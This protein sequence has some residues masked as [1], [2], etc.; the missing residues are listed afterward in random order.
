MRNRNVTSNEVSVDEQAFKNT[1]EVTVDEEGFEVVDETVEFRPSVEMEIQAKVDS[2]HPNGRQ[3][4]R[5][6]NRS[7]SR[8]R[9]F[10]RGP[11]GAGFRGS[12]PHV[13]GASRRFLLAV[14]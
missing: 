7:A 2:N 14:V 11:G 12:T 13:R 4:R 3:H 9:G 6:P 1:D 8:C 10:R 5:R